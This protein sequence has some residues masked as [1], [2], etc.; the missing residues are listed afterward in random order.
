MEQSRKSILT[1]MYE[2]MLLIR[3]F[4]ERITDLAQ[5]GGRVL[6]MQ[7]LATGQEAGC[8]GNCRGPPA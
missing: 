8:R 3:R 5:E 2:K 6:G 7:I 4:E 1:G